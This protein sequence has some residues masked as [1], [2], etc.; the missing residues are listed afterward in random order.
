ME[1][2]SALNVK[3][4]IIREYAHHPQIDLRKHHGPLKWLS[5]VDLQKSPPKKMGRRLKLIELQLQ[6]DA[7]IIKRD[8][9]EKIENQRNQQELERKKIQRLEKDIEYQSQQVQ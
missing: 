1:S 9:L 6:D 4:N 7:A 8:Q 5:L 2:K 3:N